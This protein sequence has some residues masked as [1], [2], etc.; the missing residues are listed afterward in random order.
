MGG[1]EEVA[2]MGCGISFDSRILT[3]S[4][5][6]KDLPFIGHLPYSRH[7]AIFFPHSIV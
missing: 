2:G 6:E 3:E 5:G 7:C 4:G 1:S